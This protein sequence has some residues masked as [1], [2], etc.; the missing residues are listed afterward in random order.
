MSGKACQ[1]C[2][3]SEI[4]ADPA[5]G[6]A[7]CTNCGSVLEDQIIVSEVQFQ[8]NAAG[9]ASVIGQFVSND[10]TKSHSFGAAFSHGIGRDS[11]TVTLQNAKRKIQEIGSQLR[12]NQ[13]CLDTAF[14]FF[15]M[16]V[17]K[18]LTRGRKTAHVIATCLYLVCR[19]EGTPHM[20][21]DFSDILQVNVYVLGKTFLHIS[22]ELCLNIPAIGETES[23]ITTVNRFTIDTIVGAV[24]TPL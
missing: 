19:T 13:H 7:V 18:R 23:N 3:C 9:G 8:E 11:K 22:K 17:S 4:D 20:L 24:H 14:N 5:R 10:G 15:K 21:L 2:G 6:D 1:H 16:A 12:L